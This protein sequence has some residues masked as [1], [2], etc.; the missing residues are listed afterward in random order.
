MDLSEDT[1]QKRHGRTG[2]EHLSRTSFEGVA[3]MRVP[4]CINF[5]SDGMAWHGMA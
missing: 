3:S 2:F 1:T 4:A 5:D